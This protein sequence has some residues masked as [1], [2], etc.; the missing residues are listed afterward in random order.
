ML[1]SFGEEE[2]QTSVDENLSETKGLQQQT[3]ADLVLLVVQFWLFC[4]EFPEM[5]C[6]SFSWK[7]FLLYSNQPPF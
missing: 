1:E 2:S 6:F 4:F 5:N 3:R 7:Y